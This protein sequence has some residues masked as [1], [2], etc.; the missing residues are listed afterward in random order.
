MY[1]FEILN[2][3]CSQS[4]AIEDVPPIL[5]ALFECTLEMI[6]KNLEEFPEHR[7]HFFRMLQAITNHCFTGKPPQALLHW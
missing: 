1:S 4:Q 2:A 7:T 3:T 5:D 6:N